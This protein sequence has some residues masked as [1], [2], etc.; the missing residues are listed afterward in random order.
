MTP[1]K[2]MN[3]VYKAS[4]KL[5]PYLWRNKKSGNIRKNVQKNNVV[6]IKGLDRLGVVQQLANS[7]L[8]ILFR[9]SGGH[10]RKDWLLKDDLKFVVAGTPLI[11]QPI[12]DAIFKGMNEVIPDKELDSGE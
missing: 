4:K 1:I 6:Y 10:I 3:E 12:P 9:D 11:D 2:K 7:Q 8:K 5:S